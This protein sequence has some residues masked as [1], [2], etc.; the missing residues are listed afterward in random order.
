MK[1]WLTP[2]AIQEDFLA[3]SVVSACYEVACNTEAANDWEKKKYGFFGSGFHIHDKDHCGQSKNQV[4]VTDKNNNVISMKE[5]GT[6]ALNGHATLPCTIYTDDTY[7]VKESVQ[8][9]TKYVGETVYWMTTNK[10]GTE[11]HHQGTFTIISSDH[12]LRS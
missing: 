3:N 8:N 9:L 1:K 4:L 5:V 11:F 12:P 7:Q 2:S 10:W 6:N